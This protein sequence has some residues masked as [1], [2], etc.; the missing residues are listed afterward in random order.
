MSGE[1]KAVNVCSVSI[2]GAAFNDI[3]ELERKELKGKSWNIAGFVSCPR[4]P[5]SEKRK[6]KEK[7]N[8][9]DKCCR[10]KPCRNQSS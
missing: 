7:I 4:N 5:E 2:S 9:K 3:A 8:G 1:S 6:E 10:L